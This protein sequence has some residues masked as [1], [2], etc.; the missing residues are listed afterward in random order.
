ME[1]ARKKKRNSHRP[2]LF[3]VHLVKQK[4]INKLLTKKK[5]MPRLP[6]GSEEARQRMAHL[7][8]LRKKKK[9]IVEPV[10]Q[11]AQMPSPPPTDP[12]SPKSKRKRTS[13][14]AHVQEFAKKN[15]M[16]YFQ[17]LGDPRVKEGYSKKST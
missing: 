12:D 17:A 4:T 11:A 15:N 7:R 6:K 16:N 1:K 3:S 8:S 14:I 13:W 10:T 2:N 5:P 9:G